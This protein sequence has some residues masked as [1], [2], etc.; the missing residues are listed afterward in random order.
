M[1]IFSKLFGNRNYY[2]LVKQGA[3]GAWRWEI[4]KRADNSVVAISTVKGWAS[5]LQAKD[6]AVEFMT[7]IG[8]DRLEVKYVK[9]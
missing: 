3:A 9:G 4:I 1:S 2:L 8:A 7:A 6:H 5:A